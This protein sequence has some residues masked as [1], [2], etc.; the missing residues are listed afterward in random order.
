MIEL[1]KIFD[2]II[3]GRF[4]PDT[5]RAGRFKVPNHF[6]KEIEV[7][8]SFTSEAPSAPDPLGH[9]FFGVLV[10]NLSCE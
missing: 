4:E 9:L 5:T 1:R 3:A 7:E 6:V 10:R 8:T 2:S